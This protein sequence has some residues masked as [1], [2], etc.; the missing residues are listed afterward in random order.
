MALEEYVPPQT[1][2]ET[3][4]RLLTP[5]FLLV[6]A[7]TFAYFVS[8]GA[9]QPTLPRFVEGPLGR[10]DVA[11]GLVIGAFAFSAVIIRPAVGPL[12]DRK[13]RRLL[14]VAGAGIVTLSVVGYTVADSL[15]PLIMLRLLAGAGEALFYVGA[16][17]VINDLAP[18]AR[19]GEA[20]SCFSLA[21]YSGLTVGP[22]L[23]ELT[24]D[25]S[26]F[27]AVWLV[28]A[29][30]A[31]I[32]A[33][34]GLAVKDTRPEGTSDKRTFRWFHPAGLLPGSVLAASIL[35]L[36]GFAT[37]IPLYAL[38]LGM[39]GSRMVFVTFSAVVMLV[40]SVG[41]R[42]PD[43]LGPKRAASTA[44]GLQ[45]SGLTIMGLWQEPVGLF[46]GA[47]VFGLGQALAFPAL[48]T[49]AIRSAPA[50]ERSAVVGTFTAF[51]DLAFGLGA[52]SLGGVASIAGYG[53]AFVTAA[54]VAF[55]GLAV[56]TA[57]GRR[58]PAQ[59]T[60]REA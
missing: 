35:G 27:D 10:G 56:L 58:G 18:E 42:I 59:A 37:F 50:T 1:K 28:A 32:A 39:D 5:L 19:R 25:V 47:F 14:M 26:T 29:A 24:L 13:G 34:F 46:V 55:G 17:S 3:K 51:F 11:V 38:D 21:L 6:T 54:V 12:G 15:P 8:V 48:M 40:R 31:G 30:S 44:L 22:V 33:L 9:L 7:S 41:A 49:M 23:G 60:A 2:V 16:A 20:L 43:M 57:R 4:E 52:I 45:G 53:G 36:G